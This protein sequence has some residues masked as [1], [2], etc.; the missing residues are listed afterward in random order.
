[1]AGCGVC[2][3]LWPALM[4]ITGDFKEKSG[5]PFFVLRGRRVN[6]HRF[7]F[8]GLYLCSFQF[9]LYAFFIESV[10]RL[11]G[12]DPGVHPRKR[13]VGGGIPAARGG[14]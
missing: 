11:D 8:L 14:I 4:E 7:L 3:G 12:G 5:V 10:A 1:M 13:S 6:W 9:V 2:D